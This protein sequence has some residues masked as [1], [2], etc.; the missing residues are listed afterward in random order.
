MYT[1]TYVHS[2]LIRCLWHAVEEE[3]GRFYDDPANEFWSLGFARHPDG[4]FSADLFG[5]SLRPRRVR[6]T[7][8][9][10]YW[11]VEF[12]A[13][14]VL[15]GLSKGE[16]LDSHQ[17]LPIRGRDFFLGPTGRRIPEHTEWE[18]FL[19]QLEAE[20][21]LWSDRRICRALQ[22]NTEGISERNRQRLFRQIT[23]LTKKQIE[24]L[25]RA[26]QAF[27]L[28]QNG[29]SSVEAALEAGYADQS[30]MIRA[31]RQLRGQTPARILSA[32]L[33]NQ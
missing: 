2:T 20:G 21:V 33:K 26:R 24:Q 14:V 13:H 23:G 31:F 15:S 11:G 25:Q 19:R 10:E 22:G 29:R 32:Y 30:H 4:T 17:S 6:S 5:P 8:G 28:L 7:T 12:H 27:F 1:L 3:E 18:P 16:V 9:D